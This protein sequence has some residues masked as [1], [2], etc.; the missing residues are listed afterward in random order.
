MDSQRDDTTTRT[1]MRAAPVSTPSLLPDDP[2][3]RADL[4]EDRRLQGDQDWAE[5][6][7]EA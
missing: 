7:G 6:G 3:E 5:F 1:R 4:Q 2:E